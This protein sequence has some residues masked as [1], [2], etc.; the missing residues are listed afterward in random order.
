MTMLRKWHAGAWTLA[1]LCVGNA[2]ADE[3]ASVSYAALYKPVCDKYVD[4]FTRLTAGNYAVWEGK[5]RKEL[6]RIHADPAFQE[7]LERALKTPP[8][9]FKA[10]KVRQ[11]TVTCETIARVFEH[12]APAQEQF[13][14]P[15]RTWETFRRALSKADRAAIYACLTGNARTIFAGRLHAMSDEQLRRMNASIAELKLATNQG[16]YQEGLVVQ[17]DGKAGTVVFVKTGANWKIA[18][19]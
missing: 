1:V 4:G 16:S 18:D 6:E 12:E 2:L 17:K 13:G 11:L 8:E 10:T 15:E 5:H 7:R 9:D 14:A 19:M 3:D